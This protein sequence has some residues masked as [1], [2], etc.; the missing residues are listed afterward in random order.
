MPRWGIQSHTEGH[1]V[2][3][4]DTYDSKDNTLETNTYISRK[5]I[6]GKILMNGYIPEAVQASIQGHHPQQP[7]WAQTQ[8][9]TG[10]DIKTTTYRCRE[11]KTYFSDADTLKGHLSTTILHAKPRFRCDICKKRYTRLDILRIHREQHLRP[12]MNE[13]RG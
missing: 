9:C 3:P 5:P 2:R 4:G 7:I 10:I 8:G 12:D 13:A 11:C 6:R 1:V